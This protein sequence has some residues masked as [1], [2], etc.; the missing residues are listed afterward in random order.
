MKLTL[1]EDE[2]ALRDEVRAYLA[3]HAPG[4]GDVPEDLDGH[5][6][7]MREWQRDAQRAG[8]V[9]LS[10]PEK[11]GGRGAS[12][13]EQIVVNREMAAAGVPQLVGYVGVDVL[14]PTLV[15]HGTDEQKAAGCSGSSP[16]RTSGAR[17]SPSPAPALTSPR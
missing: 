3:E 14:G 7:Y 2:R 10:W 4:P 16:A 1:S 13:S 17:A 5:V 8:L 6:A 12:L 11:Y 15:E 9:G